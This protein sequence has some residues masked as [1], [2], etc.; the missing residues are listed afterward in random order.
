MLQEGVLLSAAGSFVTVL[1]V[2]CAVYSLWERQKLKVRQR[3]QAL[4]KNKSENKKNIFSRGILRSSKAKAGSWWKN[5]GWMVW[6]ELQLARANIPLKSGELLIIWGLGI[7]FP[8]CGIYLITMRILPAVYYAALGILIP[9]FLLRRAKERKAVILND[10]LEE[11]LGTISNA[12]RAG[13]GLLQALEMV[14]RE[15]RPPLAN[16]IKRTLKEITLGTPVEKALLRCVERTG[17]REL[18]MVVTVV[19][20]QRQVGGNL[21]RILDRI[22][23]T[24]RERNRI[25]GE[26]KTLT[27]QGKIS[28]IVIGAIP[29]VLA[30]LLLVMNP[31]YI[32]KFF[33]QP[34]GIA[35][36]LGGILS[37]L[38]GVILIKRIVSINF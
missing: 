17:S 11:A 31:G 38:L 3:L 15:S 6:I 24:I 14:S 30:L 18:E 2:M 7:I 28:G 13:F 9:L 36:L 10:Q 4:A 23:H 22:A 33:S 34:L 37:Q 32:S 19:N 20:I 8:A 26:I 16:E 21:A 1:M 5:K 27:A 35:L 29:P 12:L 25:R